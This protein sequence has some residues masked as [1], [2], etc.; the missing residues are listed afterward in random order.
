MPRV[1]ICGI[2]RPEDAEQAAALGA[3]A[4]GFI[5]W[6]Q[7][8][9]VADPAVAAGIARA[10][11]RRVE[12]VGVFVNPT[13]DEVVHAAEGIELTYVQ[14]HGDEGPAFCTAVAERT[15][16]RV[17]KAL[18]IGSG[19]DIR[20]AERYHTELHLLDTAAGSAYGGTGR[21]WDWDLV[22]QRRSNDPADPVR[23]PHSRQRRGGDRGGEA[24]GGRRQLGR[25][26]GARR[27]G[28]GQGRGV[29]R[30]R[31]GH[32]GG[33]VS[34]PSKLGL[35]S[36]LREHRAP[37]VE[38]R[39][40]EYGGQYVPET[41]MPALAELEAA[42]VAARA[43]EG[44]KAELAT[45]LR[46]FAGRPTPLYH[47]KRLS[48]AA[49][50]TV[51]LKREDLLHTGAHK[52]NNAL[53]QTLLA[54]RM[55]KT[56]I[57]AETGAGQHGVA[58]ATACALL[59]L[60]CVVY[61]GT[62]DMRRQK[63]NVQRMGLLGATVAP[64]EA[65][66]RTLKEA[67]SAAIRDWVANVGGTHYVIGSCVGPAPFPALVRDLQRV[68]GDEA[69]AQVLDVAGRLPDRVIACVG[70][71]SNAIG[72][73]IPFVDD[74]D[75]E[76]IGVE[77]AGEGIATGRHGAPLTIGGRGGV[78]H[79]AYSAIMQDEDGQILEAHSISAGLDYPGTGPEHAHLRD[80][81][82]ARY[83]AV[84]D[85]EALA[86]LRRV[87]ELEGIIPALE[88]SHAVTWALRGDAGPDTLDLVCLSGRGDKDLAEV[89]PKLGLAE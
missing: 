30:G 55:G 61:M 31:P 26:G 24:V 72:T 20:S 69:R 52:I 77:A 6:P 60:D 29:L 67:V 47:A 84:T 80:S 4:I 3:W 11:R 43:D 22:A 85:E 89:L 40:G 86:T 34:G 27:Q 49:G 35:A 63:P 87:C 5:L 10:L 68:I 42:W 33:L 44:F 36:S 83:V 50:H 38:H 17:I 73:F 45:L 25:R 21:T 2:T 57:I 23:R 15:G 32:R 18:G 13:L 76:L 65:G 79:G 81:G 12:I 88:S 28:P 82:R 64:V 37:A 41:L 39:F 74:A 54:K 53:G 48:E 75:V 8:K 14:L 56:R 59:G 71:G 7:S 58:T 9:R 70:G 46:D 51:Y 66:A 19:A 62:E 16:A 1:K 78:L